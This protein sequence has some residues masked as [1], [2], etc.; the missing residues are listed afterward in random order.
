MKINLPK[1]LKTKINKLA[2]ADGIAHEKQVQLSL[3]D[4]VARRIT[5]GE[6]IDVICECLDSGVVENRLKSNVLEN[7]KC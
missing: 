6:S 5:A 3:R 1:N 7:L 2:H 4:E